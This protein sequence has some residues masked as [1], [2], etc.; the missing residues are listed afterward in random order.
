MFRRTQK[1]LMD[2]L[3]TYGD[4]LSAEELAEIE[5]YRNNCSELKSTIRKV[6]T[7]INLISRSTRNFEKFDRIDTLT[8]IIIALDCKLAKH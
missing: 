6:W 7:R 3:P 1:D 5:K 8:K 4:I 2:M